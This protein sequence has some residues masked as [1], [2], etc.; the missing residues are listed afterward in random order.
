MSRWLKNNTL[1]CQWTLQIW[2]GKDSTRFNETESLQ[3][4]WVSNQ[5]SF[6]KITS[7]ARPTPLMQIPWGGINLIEWNIFRERK[8]CQSM[9][10]MLLKCLFWWEFPWG[11]ICGKACM[12]IGKE[13]GQM[14]HCTRFPPLVSTQ[15]EHCSWLCSL[16]GRW[17]EVSKHQHCS[18]AKQHSCL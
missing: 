4:A 12:H 14:C 16:P 13:K 3:Y 15:K 10:E 9:W 6:R 8:K 11:I 7:K 2:F 5:R 18:F 17:M 1:N